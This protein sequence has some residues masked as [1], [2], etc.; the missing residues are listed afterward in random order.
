MIDRVKFQ[1]ENPDNAIEELI[2][3]G[4]IT[5]TDFL[6]RI[7]AR[8]NIDYFRSM[9]V[10]ILISWIMEYFKNHG[11]APGKEIEVIY[12]I[13][14]QQD[15][16]LQK[17]KLGS[18]ITIALTQF[19][20]S[21]NIEYVLPKALQYFRKQSLTL[22]MEMTRHYLGKDDL[23]EAELS[24]Y[25]YKEVAQG[26]SYYPNPFSDEA[27][28]LW[29]EYTDEEL[30]RFP[31]YLGKYLA[32]ICR[33]QLIGVMGPPKRGKTTLLTEFACIALMHKLK[34]VFFSL[35]MNRNKI[36]Q[37]IMTR[38][39]GRP[40]FPE[41]YQDLRIPVMDC[42]KNQTGECRYP[43]RNNKINLLGEDGKIMGYD[44][45]LDGRYKPCTYCLKKGSDDYVFAVWY[46]TKRY[47]HATMKDFQNIRD[48]F[49]Q[50]FGGNNLIVEAYPI[51][52]F[53]CK[54]LENRLTL[55]EQEKKIFFDVVCIPEGSLVLTKDRGLVPIEQIEEQ[56]MLWDGHSWVNHD[57]IIYKGEREIIE[58][59]GIK[60]TPN[61]L[62]W[63]EI[64][65]R[66]LELCKRLGL[67][68]AQTEHNG[69]NLRVGKNYISHSEGSSEEQ[70]Q[71]RS[72]AI[73]LLCP[74]KMYKMWKGKVDFLWELKERSIK[75]L[76]YLFTTKK[77][78]SMALLSGNWDAAKVRE[79]QTHSLEVLR[80]ERNQI[81][82]PKYIRSLFMDS[83]KFRAT[84]EQGVR[85]R[86]DKQQQSLQTRESEMVHEETELPTHNTP[87][88]NSKS[89]PI[90]RVVS[91]CKILR[92]YIKKLFSKKY[93]RENSR[94]VG[95]KLKQ[96]SRVWD[97]RNAGPFHCFTVQGVLAHNC[98]DYA[99][100]MKKEDRRER[101]LEI[102]SIWEQLAALSQKKNC[103]VVT[104]S[105]TNRAATNK[106]DLTM[107]D[108][109][110]DYS[111]AMI[112]DMFLAINQTSQEKDN[113]IL[114]IA[115]VLH[116]HRG[117]SLHHQCRVIQA[118]EIG[119][120]SLGSCGAARKLTR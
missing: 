69:R 55:L 57:G 113:S 72:K 98:I 19:G 33:G 112:A 66:S 26:I 79:P 80:S 5:Q 89:L 18:L 3:S 60:A 117:F 110:E 48:D 84:K 8:I 6:K 77:V 120:F 1:I 15:D 107:E 118:P 104:A 78:P 63:T 67:R 85:I 58:Y 11:E 108:L 83:R 95:P 20:E 28:R 40:K 119:Q 74:Y 106:A 65:W 52:T 38:I 9:E 93:S 32:P 41:K 30:L 103:L 111:K 73:W 21:F 94:A 49:K 62:F 46:Q 31:G 17:K 39:A 16:P 86:S 81:P 116:R 114:R 115:T 12:R 44:P 64:G 14:S 43:Q 70:N 75:R 87:Y 61:H 54:D 99:D 25:K 59:A 97:I 34:V 56:D 51:G 2:L 76:S 29:W 42:L 47:Q 88:G 10:R 109:A 96:T 27:I 7:A 90:Q 13:E 82:I 101:R 23:E 91:S 22:A 4:M 105:Q 36:N 102:G 24:Y 68:I 100:I 37:K 71:E 45:K 92:Q 50:I 53:S 35:E